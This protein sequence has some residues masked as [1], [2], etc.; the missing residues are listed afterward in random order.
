MKKIIILL[1]IN[2]LSSCMEAEKLPD[3][4]ILEVS[5]EDKKIIDSLN[6]VREQISFDTTNVIEALCWEFV[7]FPD[8]IEVLSAYNEVSHP[9]NEKGKIGKPFLD[10]NKIV[11]NIILSKE[12]EKSEFWKVY[13]DVIDDYVDFKQKTP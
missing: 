5:K 13:Y 1:S 8:E 4:V 12:N 6:Y 3:S 11:L 9:F 10:T 2:L 7:S